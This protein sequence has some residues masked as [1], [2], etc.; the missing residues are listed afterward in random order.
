MPGPLKQA[1]LALVAYAFDHRGE[2]DPPPIALAEP[3][4]APYRR[5]RL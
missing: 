5:V 1:I 4:L 2:A 3:W